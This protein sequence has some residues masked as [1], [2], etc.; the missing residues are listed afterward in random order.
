LVKAILAFIICTT[1][2]WYPVSKLNGYTLNTES[3]AKCDTS[4]QFYLQN[5]DVYLQKTEEWVWL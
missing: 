1:I 2:L 4:F 3:T 5:V